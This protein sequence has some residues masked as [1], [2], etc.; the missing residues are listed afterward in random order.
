MRTSP[1]GAESEEQIV[2]L[3]RH[4]ALTGLPNR[5]VFQERLGQALVQAERA[6]GIRAALP[7]SRPIQERST[8]TLG[9]PIGD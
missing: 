5:V 6:E 2:F 3:A 7:R 8:M 9:H 4:D 1:N